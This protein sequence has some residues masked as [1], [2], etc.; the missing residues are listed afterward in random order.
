MLCLHLGGWDA[1][2][3]QQPGCSRPEESSASG[4]A[5]REGKG[6]WMPHLILK[7]D[8]DLAEWADAFDT[9]AIR[10]QRA[11]LKVEDS[12]LRSDGAALLVEG[13]VVEFSRPLHPVAFVGL[14]HGNT[15]VRLWARG[16]VE[17]TEAVNDGSALLPRSSVQRPASP[18]TAP[19][20]PTEFC[21]TWVCD[22]YPCYWASSRSWIFSRC[23]CSMFRMRS[24]NASVEEA[25]GALPSRAF[26]ASCSCA[27]ARARTLSV[28]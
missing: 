13:I 23:A 17:R 24:R 14:H 26:R 27:S 4:R 8:V 15:I 7:G 28:G 20:F 1:T 18:F 2:E 12:W 5:S 25:V 9:S 22:P 19:T 3:Q 11:V 6:W 10:W 21:R 16:G